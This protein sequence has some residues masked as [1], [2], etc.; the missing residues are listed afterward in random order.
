MLLKSKQL[1]LAN[2]NI[3]VILASNLIN[4]FLM[5]QLY[6]KIIYALI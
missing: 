4:N 1:A 2:S 6:F 5:K 3:N